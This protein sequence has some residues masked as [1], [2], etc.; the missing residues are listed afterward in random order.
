MMWNGVNLV[1]FN[2]YSIRKNM[3]FSNK[4][5]YKLYFFF[6]MF[7]TFIIGISFFMAFALNSIEFGWL[8]VLLIVQLLKT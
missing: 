8:E 5:Q 3:I 7:Y 6:V 2:R 4:K 1:T